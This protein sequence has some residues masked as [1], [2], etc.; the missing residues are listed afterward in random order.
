MRRNFIF[1]IGHSTRQIDDFVHLLKSHGVQRVVD[2]RTLPRSRFNPQFD[3]TRLPA[4][5]LAA[6][7]HYTHLPGL[8]GLRRPQ[9]DSPNVGWRNK[10]FR[11][12]ADHMQSGDF[13]RSLER[14]L[15]LASVERVALMC[16]EAVPW[17]CHRSLIADALVARGI[18]ALEIASDSRVRPH[19]L[20]PFAQ[21]D[22]THVTYP[23]AHN[24][25]TTAGPP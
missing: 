17:R 22:G 11:G 10:S 18:D 20:T 14:C 8:G 5:L 16:A 6:H 25:S 13:Q 2:V 9:H 24:D 23:A 7:I 1:T 19:T 3:I 15:E 4:L 21:V 12:Y